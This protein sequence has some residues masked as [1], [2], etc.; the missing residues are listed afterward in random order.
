MRF[1]VYVLPPPGSTA[2]RFGA[3][4][5]GWD[6]ETGRGGEPVAVDGLPRE[7]H[8]RIVSG[9]RRYGFHATLVAPFVLAAGE[10]RSSLEEATAALAGGIA[11]FRAPG[12]EPA[13]LGRDLVLVLCAPCAAM[14]ELARRLVAGLDRFRRPLP[15]GARRRGLNRRQ[16]ALL[17]RWGYPWVM[18]EFRFHMTLAGPLGGEERCAVAGLLEPR[19]APL[20]AG[21]WRVDCVCLLGQETR[22][23]PFTLLGRFPLAGAL[24]AA[25]KSAIMGRDS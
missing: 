4:W 1:A 2:A 7:T 21:D 3:A 25:G 20:I 5:L 15:D 14:D 24:D 17:R 18:E 9:P 6:P 10:T 8:R 16:E 23:G 22:G 11:A 13:F 12:L 19:L